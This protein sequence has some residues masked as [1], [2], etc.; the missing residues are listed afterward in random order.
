MKYPV[1]NNIK[2][3]HNY[4]KISLDIS[5]SQ[6]LP[7]PGQFYSVL[8]DQGTDPLLR[9]PFSVHR[10]REE[11]GRVLMDI[12]YL[13][14]GKGTTWLSTRVKGDRVDALGPFGNGFL[15]ENGMSDLVLVSRGIGIAPLYA[16]GQTIKAKHESARIH[17]LLGGRR[18]DR[19][20]YEDECSRIGHVHTYTDDGSLGFKGRAPDLLV[21]ML[22]SAVI[23]SSYHIMTCGPLPMLKEL[24]AIAREWNLRGQ[25]AL[26]THMGCGFGA[27]LSCAFPLLP[28][29]IVFGGNWKKPALQWSEDARVV[30]SLICKDGP[31]YDIH[32]VD[33]D[34]W[35]S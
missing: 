15:I 31:I 17:V 32:E 30:Y 5:A 14:L 26:E 19:V 13:V 20:F 3:K 2:V 4:Y 11:K 28:E 35:L 21:H 1:T 22:K 10:V 8:C 9:R 23:S 16:V 7:R 12:L 27:C 34:E 25:V 33:W 18:H 29:R 24:S 6:T